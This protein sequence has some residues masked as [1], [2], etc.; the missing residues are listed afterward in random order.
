[1]PTKAELMQV[2]TNQQA[3]DI[4]VKVAIDTAQNT[5]SALIAVGAGLIALSTVGYMWYRRINSDKR[6]DGT[7]K[8]ILDESARA[9]QMWRENYELANKRADEANHR[10]DK[11]HDESM[12]VIERVAKERNDAVQNA[13]KLAATVEHLQQTVEKQTIMIQ[14]L[15]KENIELHENIEGLSVL[16]HQVLANQAAIYEKFEIKMPEMEAVK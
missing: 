3:S 13:G 11:I 7:L 8:L 5:N 10:A 1:M 6:E 14:S 9:A 12:Q 2:L 15:E 16:L 4:A